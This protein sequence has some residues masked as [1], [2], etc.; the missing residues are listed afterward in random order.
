MDEDYGKFASHK[1]LSGVIANEKKSYTD[2]DEQIMRSILAKLELKYPHCS[3]CGGKGH[4]TSTCGYLYMAN[5]ALNS[6]PG[7][8]NAWAALKL[9][10]KQIYEK[11]DDV[12]NNIKIDA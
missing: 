4:P 9:K 6:I 3:L 8:C 12:I 11:K 2:L 5:K 7:V 1:K 10:N